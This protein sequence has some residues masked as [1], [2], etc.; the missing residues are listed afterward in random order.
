MVRCI[1]PP[2]S[3]LWTVHSGNFLQPKVSQCSTRGSNLT[4][5]D[6]LSVIKDDLKTQIM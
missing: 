6:N 5:T 4:K 1:G 2:I 3:F